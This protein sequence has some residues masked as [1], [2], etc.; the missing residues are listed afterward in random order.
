MLTDTTL[1]ARLLGYLPRLAEGAA[2]TLGLSLVAIVCGFAMGAALLG[3][4]LRPG[5][6]GLR[7]R[8]VALYV[9]FFRGT[10]LLVQLLMLFYL[11]SALGVDLPPPLAA[12]MALGLNSAAFQ[13]EILRAGLAA[14]P[15]GQ[16]EAA[17]VFGLTP[18]QTFSQIQLPQ[19]AVAVWPTLVS[20][21]IDV[22]KGSAI[23]SVIA[24]TD[25]AR[26]GR[27]IVAGNFRPLE[28]YLA[29]AVS[30]L[31]L[32]LLLV[33]AGWVVKRKLAERRFRPV[34]NAILASPFGGS[35]T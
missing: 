27:Q 4:S 3:L 31:L 6:L 9:S 16:I 21:A 30:Y 12:M 8:T 13:C 19:I 15:H 2:T 34:S 35:P 1:G 17:R 29:V 14:I 28:V 10:P 18:R 26:I 23:V 24:V 22:L 20:E 11:P 25:L 7:Q 5:L 33:A 32:A